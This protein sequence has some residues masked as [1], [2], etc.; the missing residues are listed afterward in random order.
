[1]PRTARRPYSVMKRDTARRRDKPQGTQAKR[2]RDTVKRQQTDYKDAKRDKAKDKRQA[3]RRQRQAK[4]QA[5]AQ[6]IL[7]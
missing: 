5:S 2:T 4:R 3:W 1:M 7:Q 6:S